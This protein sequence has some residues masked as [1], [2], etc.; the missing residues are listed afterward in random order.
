MKQRTRVVWRIIMGL[1]CVLLLI[2]AV[3][4]TVAGLWLEREFA[5]DVAIAEFDL[6]REHSA[7]PV[8]YR[9]Q[10][11]DRA[12]RV[13]EE[14]QIT[15]GVAT[16]V[17]IPYLSYQEIPADMV[18]AIVAIED[19]HFFEHRGVD[20]K[21]TFAAGV[22][23]VFGFSDRFGA[24]TITQQL[25]KNVTG[26]NEISPRRKIREVFLAREL[27]RNYDKTEIIERYLNILPLSDGCQG[28]AAGAERFFGKSVGELT[29]AQCATLA[30]MTNNPTYYHPV[31][32]PDHA[33]ARRDLILSQM[34]EQGYLNE[35]SYRTAVAEPLGVTVQE[36][37]KEPELIRSWYLDMVVDDVITDLSAS[38]G[39]SREA[40]SR[41]VL[42]GGLRIDVAMDGD[43]QR[44]VENYYRTLETP[45]NENGEAAQSALMM[46]DAKTGDILAVA[47]AVGTKT[48]NR[49]Q[50]FAT[51][52]KRPPGSAIKPVTVYGPALELGKITWGSVYDDVP[53]EFG[54]NENR[55]WPRN[56]SGVYR[57]LTDVSYA[58][59]QSTNTVAV[60][61]LQDVGISESF[62]F[63]TEKFHLNG[64]IGEGSVHDRNAAA[65]ALGQMSY[66][67]TLRELTAAYTVFAD[68]GVY[69]PWRSYYRVTDAEGNLLL[70]CPDR[71]ETVLKAENAAIMTKLLQGV[72]RGGTSSSVTLGKICECAGKTGTTQDDRDRWFVGYTPG[73][74]CGVWC[75]FPYPEPIKG[76]NPCLPVWNTVMHYAVGTYGGEKTFAVP[77]NVV[78]CT[79]CRD[80]GKLPGSACALD[81]RGNRSG[82]GWF[83]KGTEPS[84]TCD[85]HVPVNVWETGGVCH[86]AGAGET[87]KAALIRV[88]PRHFPMQ[89]TV[90][91]AQYVYRGDPYSLP[92]NPNPE[93]AYFETDSADFCGRSATQ[94]PFN[95]SG[96]PPEPPKEE[97]DNRFPFPW[98][99]F[100]PFRREENTEE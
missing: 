29:V 90:S 6:S 27:E 53:V 46:I 22:N 8:F 12:N 78:P 1:I 42:T 32:N 19:K 92:R 43:L 4:I 89:I 83:V 79:Y 62:R 59:A 55:P 54:S 36:T 47:G 14:V 96:T 97:P 30:A 5:G 3:A 56:A 60:R 13:G 38:L 41:R 95:R 84:A 68:G 45:K 23:Y 21:R 15:E 9:F 52:T 98:E 85:C 74:I 93:E 69:H 91:D 50:N 61:V 24:S 80:S 72:I 25:V 57:G 34:L 99:W 2:L 70:S 67:V 31:Q 39:I 20:W 48:A 16:A 82:V 28:I 94:T 49:V 73:I 17:E 10:F 11:T 71:A 66:G 81:P 33:L 35:E 40:A 58:V 44:Y 86:E 65:L 37:R 63:A 64:L 88:R 75:G 100:F 76:S 77:G 51:Q 18:N 26:E 7:P 87:K